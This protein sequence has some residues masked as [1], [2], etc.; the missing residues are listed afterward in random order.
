MR[1]FQAVIVFLFALVAGVFAAEPESY[2]ATV[3]ITSTLYR[4]NTVTMQSS[5]AYSVANQTSTIPAPTYAAPS[6]TGSYPA[7][8]GTG[9]VKPT[10]SATKPST[11]EF[12]GAA[13]SLNVN[14][15]VVA[16]VAG[17]SYL[18]L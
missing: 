13:S 17:A 12:T 14:A 3:Y 8:N 10:G 15:L 4:V 7:G 11:P 5:P 2:D 6:V 16:L 9:I 1:S 18:V